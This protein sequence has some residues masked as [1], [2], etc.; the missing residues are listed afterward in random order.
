MR[1]PS[2]RLRAAPW[3]SPGPWVS[4]SRFYADI[5]L[6]SMEDFVVGG[7]EKDVHIVGVNTGDFKVEGYL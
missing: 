2:S 5:D 4:T 7:N 6:L 1:R 3:A